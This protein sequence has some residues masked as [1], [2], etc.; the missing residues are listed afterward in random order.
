M[1]QHLDLVRPRHARQ[2][3]AYEGHG[4]EVRR[5][6]SARTA[7]PDGAKSI[8]AEGA[9]LVTAVVVGGHIPAAAMR[10]DG[11]GA[12][13]ALGPRAVGGHVDRVHPAPAE[14]RVGEQEQVIPLGGHRFVPGG[15]EAERLLESLDPQPDLVR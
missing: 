14:R 13:L 15:G 4:V 2:C 3:A 10:Y 6:G 12:E 9:G 7:Q 11:I 8:G 5:R 1:Q